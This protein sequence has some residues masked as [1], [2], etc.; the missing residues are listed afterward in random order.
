MNMMWRVKKHLQFAFRNGAMGWTGDM[1]RIELISIGW[2]G[3]HRA[4]RND[5]ER[6]HR[7]A[8]LLHC[9]DVAWNPNT[10]KRNMHTGV[11]HRS[12]MVLLHMIP[13]G[14]ETRKLRY[15][16]LSPEVL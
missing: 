15:F 8:W 1:E 3:R 14:I 11:T 9:M 2:I 4:L 6:R 16:A 13:V 7:S 12:S 5:H 10:N